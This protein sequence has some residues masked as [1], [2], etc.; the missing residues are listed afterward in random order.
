MPD[1]EEFHALPVCQFHDNYTREVLE[2]RDTS[3]FRGCSQFYTGHGSPSPGPLP[4]LRFFFK[5][6]YMNIF[7]RKH[8]VEFTL[9]IRVRKMELELW[10]DDT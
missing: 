8:Q 2:T 1:E 7:Q 3:E 9:Q 5:G 4:A 6:S 10:L